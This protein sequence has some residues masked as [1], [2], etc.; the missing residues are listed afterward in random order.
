VGIFLLFVVVVV[1]CGLARIGAEACA[2]VGAPANMSRP[3]PTSRSVEET[4]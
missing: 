3:L 4:L 1:V 2:T